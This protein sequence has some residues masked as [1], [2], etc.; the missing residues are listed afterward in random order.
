MVPLGDPERAL[1]HHDKLLN[2]RCIGKRTEKPLGNLFE[3]DA[4]S[5]VNGKKRGCRRWVESPFQTVSNGKHSHV[6]SYLPPEKGLQQLSGG[7]SLVPLRHPPHHRIH[8]RVSPDAQL[9]CV[10]D[11]TQ[12]RGCSASAQ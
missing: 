5:W 10:F 2:F 9:G 11:T 7:L 12:W 4:A 1:E 3:I 6:V 8:P